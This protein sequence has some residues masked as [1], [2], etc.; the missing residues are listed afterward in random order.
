MFLFQKKENFMTE[1]HLERTNLCLKE[2]EQS[3]ENLHIVLNAKKNAFSQ[4]KEAY[5]ANMQSKNAQIEA[6]KSALEA[7]VQTIDKNTQKIDEVI[8]QNGTSH[9]SH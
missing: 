1:Q 9:N 3:I 7:A 2:L 8:K 6:L 5:K 4:Q